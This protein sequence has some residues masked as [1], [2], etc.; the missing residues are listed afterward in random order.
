[1]RI[2][3]Y[4]NSLIAKLLPSDGCTRRLLPCSGYGLVGCGFNFVFWDDSDNDALVY[5]TGEGF[6]VG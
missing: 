4:R 6:G 2:F 1:M 5:G 3:F